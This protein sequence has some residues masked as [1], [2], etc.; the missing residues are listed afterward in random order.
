MQSLLLHLLLYG[1]TGNMRGHFTPVV[2]LK[3]YC[4]LPKVTILVTFGISIL[5]GR[6]YRGAKQKLYIKLVQVARLE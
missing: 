5:W 2:V 4:K 1:L 3:Y 6:Y